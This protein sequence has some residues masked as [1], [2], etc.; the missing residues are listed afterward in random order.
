MRFPD[1]IECFGDRRPICELLGNLERYQGEYHSIEE[2]RK[3][4]TLNEE[5][6]TGRC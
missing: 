2:E 5:K 1:A 4:V 3:M 6:L